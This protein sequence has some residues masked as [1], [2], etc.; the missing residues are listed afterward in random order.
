MKGSKGVDYRQASLLRQ[1][2]ILIDWVHSLVHQPRPILYFNILLTINGS[3]S[4]SFTIYILLQQKVNIS[5]FLSTL[6]QIFNVLCL[7]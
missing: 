3:S 7:S 5:F 4:L 2:H 6:D 1:A